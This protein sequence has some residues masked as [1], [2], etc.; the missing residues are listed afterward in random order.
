MQVF[1][2]DW[3]GDCRSALDEWQLFRRFQLKADFAIFYFAVVVE[4]EHCHVNAVIPLGTAEEMTSQQDF[5]FEMVLAQV[6][7]NVLPGSPLPS[8]PTFIVHGVTR[9]D[10]KAD[11]SR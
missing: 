8:R 5:S 1:R 10:R 3:V 2:F 6:G 7:D 11:R 4:M 9:P